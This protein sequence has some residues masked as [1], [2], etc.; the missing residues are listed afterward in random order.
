MVEGRG[1]RAI[2]RGAEHGNGK[3]KQMSEEDQKKVK[4]SERFIRVCSLLADA[5]SLLSSAADEISFAGEDF[6]QG[7]LESIRAHI[8]ET[9]DWMANVARVRKS[10]EREREGN[11]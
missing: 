6:F 10:Q 8:E 3:E 1:D 7:V 2:A 5:D 4:N 11:E 9:N